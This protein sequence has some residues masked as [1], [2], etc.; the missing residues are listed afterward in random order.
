MAILYK[1]EQDV[2]MQWRKKERVEP[3]QLGV[4]FREQRFTNDTRALSTMIGFS[5]GNP[6]SLGVL[7]T[8]I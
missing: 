4:V 7:P 6:Q 5:M 2:S 1:D 3:H 8:L